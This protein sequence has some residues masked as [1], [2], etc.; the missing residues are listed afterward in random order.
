VVTIAKIIL[1]LLTVSKHLPTVIDN[2]YLFWRSGDFKE[3]I[4]M[5]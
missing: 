5:F 1:N 3:K 2:N 4:H